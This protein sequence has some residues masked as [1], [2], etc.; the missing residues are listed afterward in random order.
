VIIFINVGNACKAPH[1]QTHTLLLLYF[2][3]T[4]LNLS[5]NSLYTF[6]HLFVKIFASQMGSFARQ[7][8]PADA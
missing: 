2:D 7:A 4:C 8:T 3:V 5:T 1:V 6:L